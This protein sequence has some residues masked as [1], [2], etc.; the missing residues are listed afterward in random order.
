MHTS[1]VWLGKGVSGSKLPLYRAEV[2]NSASKHKFGVT[3]RNVPTSWS[4]I[5]WMITLIVFLLMAF[6]FSAQ[7]NQRKTSYGIIQPDSGEFKI[8]PFE[9]GVISEV[10]VG[11]GDKVSKGQ[12]LAKIFPH[13]DVSGNRD[14]EASIINGVENQIEWLVAQIE[15]LHESAKLNESIIASQ[16]ETLFV[17][18]DYIDSD[19]NIMHEEYGAA[20]NNYKSGSRLYEKNYISKDHLD[21]LK[22]EMLKRKSSVAKL[23]NERSRY[24]SEIDQKK[25]SIKNVHSKYDFDKRGLEGK[26]E[27][28][29]LEKARYFASKEYVL[30]S[31]VDGM[32]SYVQLKV[33]NSVNGDMPLMSI[34]PLDATLNAE[35]YLPSRTIGGVKVGQ[36]VRIVFDAYPYEYYG[37]AQGTIKSISNSVFGVDEVFSST[38]IREPSYKVVVDVDRE[39]VEDMNGDVHLMPGMVVEA[40]IIID[41]VTLFQWLFGSLYEIRRSV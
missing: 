34:I 24:L 14:L 26:R 19:L 5:T 32:V 40:D 28:L 31:P 15:G 38:N 23:Q 21:R 35:L 9:R 18:L 12:L 7:F 29:I 3:S 30:S 10:F 25:S 16:I 33:G 6:L 17:Q 11:K 13:T 37:N 22:S 36:T 39:S 1:L 20:I 2:A 27:A 8:V 4:L 41:K